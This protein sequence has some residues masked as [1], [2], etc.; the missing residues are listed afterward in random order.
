MRIGL[1]VSANV[2]T[3]YAKAIERTVRQDIRPKRKALKL[4]PVAHC[5]VQHCKGR[6]GGGQHADCSARTMTQGSHSSFARPWHSR[7]SSGAAISMPAYSLCPAACCAL[8]P[9]TGISA[10]RDRR[11]HG[12]F[13]AERRF[14]ATAGVGARGATADCESALKRPLPCWARRRVVNVRWVRPLSPP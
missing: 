3:L 10:F 11:V 5:L 2:P 4:D 14:R 13:S 1:V 12:R 9:Q 8:R 7:R 6:G